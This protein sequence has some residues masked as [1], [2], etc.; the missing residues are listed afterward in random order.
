MLAQTGAFSLGQGVPGP[1]LKAPRSSRAGRGLRVSPL[2]TVLVSRSGTQTLR[3]SPA[4]HAA[5]PRRPRSPLVSAA[6]LLPPSGQSG[7]WFPR[8]FRC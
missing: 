5:P 8:G 1:G 2:G 3:G 6:C 4:P 7:L